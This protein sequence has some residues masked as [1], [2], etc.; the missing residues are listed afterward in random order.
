MESGD[1]GQNGV[2]C[3]MVELTI[4]RQKRQIVNKNLNDM[5]KGPFWNGY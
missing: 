3:E 2:F 4:N 1:F 5:Q